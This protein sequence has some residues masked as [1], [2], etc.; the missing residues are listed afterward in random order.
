MN[1]VQRL[2]PK[3]RNL[4]DSRKA[5]E[6]AIPLFR[7]VLYDPSFA[8]VDIEVSPFE[9]REPDFWFHP[10]THPL[11]NPWQLFV[12]M[13]RPQDLVEEIFVYEGAIAVTAGTFFHD[14]LQHVGL[15]AGILQRFPDCPCGGDHNEAESYLVDED[16]RVRGHSDGALVS[17]GD[18][19]ELKTMHPAK[20]RTLLAAPLGPERTAVFRE[21][22]PGYY[23]Q[24]QEYLRMSGRE[25]MVVLC[26][27]T[28]YPFDLVEIHIPYDPTYA[29]ATRD[30]YRRVLDAVAS[31]TFPSIHDCCGG[32]KDCVARVTCPGGSC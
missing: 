11:W 18:G 15:D 29:L 13:T 17:T 7:P 1:E 5:G 14:F 9:R 24:A 8:G 12:W 4:A 3:F 23:A 27:V 6:V 32:K 16:S 28:S 2:S 21:K 30:K 25:R 26:V 22:N 31:K 20:V 19:F 10:S